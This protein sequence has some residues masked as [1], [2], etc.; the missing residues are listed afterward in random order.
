MF[1]SLHLLIC[2]PITMMTRRSSQAICKTVKQ[3]AE[4]IIAEQ[5]PQ[6]KIDSVEFEQLTLGG[7]PP[8]FQGQAVDFF[9]CF[10]VL[11]LKFIHRNE[12]VHH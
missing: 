9:C 2:N 12:G 6:Y 4:P 7:L 5:I 10:V 11:N 8:T 1:G 3:I